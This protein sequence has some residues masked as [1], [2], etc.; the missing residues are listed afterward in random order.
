MALEVQPDYANALFGLG[1]VKERQGKGLEA[2]NYYLKALKN[3][4]ET[5]ALQD[6]LH[7]VLI[8]AARLAVTQQEDHIKQVVAEVVAELEKRS[9]K[10]I[11]RAEKVDP[12]VIARLELA[13]VHG[14]KVHRLVYNPS[15]LYLE[16]L[17]LHELMHLEF[18]L[19]AREASSNKLFASDHR[20]K[21]EFER[22]IKN[23]IAKLRKTNLP[24]PQLKEFIQSL[25]DGLNGQIFNAPLD[26][27]IEDLLFARYPEL[28]PLQ[29]LSL[30]QINQKNLQANTDKQVVEL[31]PKKVLSTSRTY[32]LVAAMQL[33]DLYAI[34]ILHE[35][36]APKREIST[37]QQ[38]WEEY[39]EYR[40]DRQAAEEY[41]LVQHWAE[42]AGV[43]AFFTWADERPS[44]V[45]DDA[46]DLLSQFLEDPFGL[47]RVDEKELMEHRT[48]LA[49]QKALGTN[50]AVVMYMVKAIQ[51]FEG[52]SPQQTQAIAFEIAM[53]GMQG[54]SPDNKNYRL[55]KI[56]NKAFTGYQLLSYYYVS[57]SIAYPDKLAELGLP[58]EEEYAAAK[59][60]VEGAS[61]QGE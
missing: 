25:F 31:T 15:H 58:Y 11:E 10:P 23:D 12:N 47:E 16:H 5:K 51:Y 17:F 7:K 45:M 40:S 55:K 36:N 24:E 43:D 9:G 44:G 4:P 3:K 19:Q 41:E 21:E 48:F 18:V 6:R 61:S 30:L 35:F 1:M 50:M 37:A 28:R 59:K 20:N 29:L 39:Q 13:E 46:D 38:W 34:D 42:D 53:L 54:I 32:N 49:K 2:F 22:A 33:K 8:D 27:F 26:L 56:P 60:L 57:W 52:L 14:R